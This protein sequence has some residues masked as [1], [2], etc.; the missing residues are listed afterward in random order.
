MDQKLVKHKKTGASPVFLL[1]PRRGE[2]A[3][4]LRGVDFFRLRTV[5]RTEPLLRVFHPVPGRPVLNPHGGSRLP[6]RR[7]RHAVICCVLRS[8]RILGC[9]G[10]FAHLP[11]RCY[12]FLVYLVIDHALLPL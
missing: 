3:L 1:S 10:G 9:L 5:A 8:V 7:V 4:C 6:F 11:V 2:S 12:F